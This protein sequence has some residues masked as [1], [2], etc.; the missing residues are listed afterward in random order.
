[1][2]RACACLCLALI[3]AALPRAAGAQGLVVGAKDFTEQYILAE[4]T[5]QLLAG[6]GYAVRTRVGLSSSGVRRE[7][8]AGLVDLYWEYTG[9]SLLAHNGVTARPSP[10]ETYARVKMLDAR[11]GLIWLKPSAVDNTYALAM[12]RSDME[13][14]GLATISD[15]A[16]LVRGGAPIRMASNTEFFVRPDGLMPLQRAYGFEFAPGSVVRMEA[17]AIYGNLRRGDAVDV[18]LVFATDGRIAAFDLQT[19]RDDR[20]FFPSYRLAPVVRRA[21]LE[22]HPT[23]ASLLE[24]LAARLDNAVIRALNASV[25]VSGRRI[26]EVARQFLEKEGLLP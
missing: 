25:D 15:L 14:R 26:E 16:A 9:T 17:D 1:M 24:S 3:C 18:G 13:A 2:R 20:G 8:E 4:M 12:R 6:R 5:R 19:L 11:K 23:L 10:D 7:Q 21:A 22:R